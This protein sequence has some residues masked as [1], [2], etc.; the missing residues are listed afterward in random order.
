MEEWI[1]AG[2]VTV[3][4][5]VAQLGTRVHEGMWFVPIDA[6]FRS[7]PRQRF[8]AVLLYHKQEGEIVSR[9]DPEHRTT[10]FDQLPRLRGMKWIAIGRLDFNTSGLL[11][12]PHPVIWPTV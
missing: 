11:I 2:L 7:N 1:A 6:P 9:E 5:V 12:S 10:V 3:N 4:G 8:A